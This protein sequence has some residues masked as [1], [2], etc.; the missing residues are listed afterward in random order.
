MVHFV[1]ERGAA[2]S[3]RPSTRLTYDDYLRLPDDGLRHEIIDGEH[4]VTASPVTR[5]Q[6]ILLNLSHL[7]QSY[8]DAHPIGE[9]FFAPVDVLLSEHD[10]VVPDLVFIST[11][12]ARVVTTKNVQ[13]APDLVVEIL[14]PSTRSRDERLKRDLYERVGVAEYW[15]V[16]P[17]RN[18]VVAYRRAPGGFDAPREYAAS[19][20][21]ATVLLPGFELSLVRLFA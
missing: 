16:D 9:L 21:L 13:G 11:E 2:V 18:L 12:R 14:S 10:I 19:E 5:H 7:I 6:R 17:E 3:R 20:T 1:L 4:Y 15:L 8:L